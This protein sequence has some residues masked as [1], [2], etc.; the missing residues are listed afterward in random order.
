MATLPNKQR[1]ELT[2]TLDGKDYLVRPT[3][4]FI[5]QVEDYFNAPLTTVVLEKLESGKITAREL[6][7]IIQAG[8][9]AAGGKV[10]EE[11]LQEAIMNTGTV[12]AIKQIVPLLLTAFSGPAVAKK[13]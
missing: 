5:C 4:N 10:T 1:N 2:I 7:V 3:F 6:V 11:E 13:K 12:D 9:E 8:I